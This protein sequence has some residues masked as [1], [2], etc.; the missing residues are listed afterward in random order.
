ML[1]IKYYYLKKSNL[2]LWIHAVK[3]C[4]Q[5]MAIL[6]WASI[7]EFLIILCILDRIKVVP[8]PKK[9]S[10]TEVGVDVTVSG[11]GKTESKVFLFVT[12]R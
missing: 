8:L 4:S 5:I 7:V 10:E 6:R 2:L 9:G 12:F 1:N 3:V 11:F